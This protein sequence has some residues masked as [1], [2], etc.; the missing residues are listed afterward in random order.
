MSRKDPYK[1]VRINTVIYKALEEKIKKDTLD[2]FKV[3]LMNAYLEGILWDYAR[4]VLTRK[5]D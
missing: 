1:V 3:P 2:E 4:G 5:T